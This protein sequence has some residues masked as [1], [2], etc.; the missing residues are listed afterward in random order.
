MSDIKNQMARGAQRW[1]IALTMEQRFS[2][3]G[4]DPAYFRKRSRGE[5]W[6]MVRDVVQ[7]AILNATIEEARASVRSGVFR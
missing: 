6:L 4:I 1:L 7:A 2:I 5:L 3:A